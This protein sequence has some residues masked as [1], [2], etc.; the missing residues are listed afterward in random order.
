M[1]KTGDKRKD[2][3]EIVEKT[4][5]FDRIFKPEV[6]V[7]ENGHSVTRAKSRL[8]LIA[9]FVCIALIISVIVTGFDI[10][11][12]ISRGREFFV[13]LGR[14]FHPDFSYFDKVWGPLVDTVEMSLLGTIVGSLLGL[15]FAILASS[16]INKNKPTLLFVRLILSVLRSVPTLII[17][18]ACSLIFGLGTFAGTVA[19]T[20]FTLGIVA[21][22][23][24][25]SIETIDMKPYEAMQSFGGS[26]LQS[27]W[28]ACIPQILPTYLSHC[29]YCFE[30]NVRAASIL[31][32][33]G[34][35]GLGILINERIGWRDY[36]GLGMV[37]L[38]LF[39]LVLIIDF[40]TDYF[41]SKL[42]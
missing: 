42:S 29:L 41:R 18:S 35:G 39:I 34:A 19:I 21:K 31:G 12:I 23:L 22:M 9:F 10:G 26:T 25:E 17:A 37:L 5:L 33:V 3:T 11:I 36:A 7:L 24:F 30:M 14:I 27:F 28:A 15:P 1:T 8:P 32:Y 6:I 4:P 20:I 40:L 38:S 16:N 13:I 2:K